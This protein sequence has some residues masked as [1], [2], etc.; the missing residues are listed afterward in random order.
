MF[1]IIQR[2]NG[3]TSSMNSL[4]SQMNVLSTEMLKQSR[5]STN[6]SISNEVITELQRSVNKLQVEF[7]TKQN[8]IKREVDKLVL[9]DD[10]SKKDVSREIK[11]LETTLSMKLEQLVNKMVKD[12]VEQMMQG[13]KMDIEREI[14]ER[15]GASRNMHEPSFEEDYEINV[16]LT[17]ENAI[18]E[19]PAPKRKGKKKT[20]PNSVDS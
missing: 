11:L 5:G 18:S 8:E 17:G 6:S 1:P 2:L 14:E 3:L 13:I 7:V 16:T 20:I 15:L 12:R 4:N 9:K 10:D 19:T